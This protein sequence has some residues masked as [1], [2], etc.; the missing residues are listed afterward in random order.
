MSPRL[1]AVLTRL[2]PRVLLGGLLFI[3][4]LIAGEGWLLV[5]SKPY[6]EYRTLITAGE[7]LSASLNSLPRKESDL[8]QLAEELRQVSAQLTGQMPAATPDDQ[9]ASEVMA[10]LDRSAAANGITLTGFRPG[11]RRQ[12]L[13]FEEVS[14]D[15]S[16][17]GKYLR[18]SQWLL[19][20]ERTLGRSA[21]V[22]EFT[23]KSAD[24]GR[25]VALNLKAV[26]YRPL[27][28][29]GAAK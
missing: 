20:F 22:S 26:L 11:V 7:S 15:V 4:G 23:M 14:F 24:E 19:D 3:A 9:M 5:L 21:T 2:D 18:L 27:R 13:E 10:S 8:A 28:A 25:L 29:P 1:I 17:Q 6:A 16:A 12:V